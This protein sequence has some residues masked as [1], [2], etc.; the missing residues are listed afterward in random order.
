[1]KTETKQAAATPLAEMNEAV[2]RIIQQVRDISAR[3]KREELDRTRKR[4]ALLR[5]RE[6]LRTQG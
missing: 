2:E 5:G 6:A 1:M 3:L 4:E